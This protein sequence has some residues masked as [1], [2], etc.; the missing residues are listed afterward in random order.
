MIGRSKKSKYLETTL[1]YDATLCTGCGMCSTVCPHGVFVQKDGIA[2]LA[3]PTA[4]ME[5][6]ACALN[7]AVRAISVDAGTGCAT[8]QM[9]ASLKGSK[10]PT[11]GSGCC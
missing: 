2:Q 4:C 6:G 5:C 10:E 9:I 11:C 8:A 7:C 1:K 3:R